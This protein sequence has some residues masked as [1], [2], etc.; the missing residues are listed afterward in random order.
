M[1]DV[2]LAGRNYTTFQAI[3]CLDSGYIE[4]PLD[5]PNLPEG[6]AGLRL[7]VQ[8]ASDPVKDENDRELDVLTQRITRIGTDVANPVVNLWMQNVVIIAGGH[9]HIIN[10]ADL[11]ID[12]DGAGNGPIN[13]EDAIMTYWPGVVDTDYYGYWNIFDGMA[14]Q[15]LDISIVDDSGL[16]VQVYNLDDNSK[17]CYFQID[18]TK[19]VLDT[20]APG[21]AYA[22]AALSEGTESEPKTNYI[23]VTAAAGVCTLVASETLP[24]GAFAWIGKIIVANAATWATEGA[25]AFQRFTEAFQNDSRGALSHVRE[26]LRA[27]GAEYISGCATSFVGTSSVPL[28]TIATGQIYQLHRQTWPVFTAGE[29]YYHGN[30]TTQN[31][32]VAN[33]GAAC[34]FLSD[35]SAIGNKRYNLII[36]GAINIDG[37]ECKVFVNLPNGSY[38]IDSQA[39]ADINN[40]AD[41]TVPDDMRSVAFMIARV[42]IS[43]T[44]STYT[45]LGVYS[46]LGQDPGARSGGTS[47]TSSNEYADSAFRI[48]DN[49]DITKMIAFEAGSVTGT[50]TMTMPN[51]NFTPV[52]G[53][54]NGVAGNLAVWTDANA[55]EDGGAIATLVQFLYCSQQWTDG[56][57]P[58]IQGFVATDRTGAS[59]GSTLTKVYLGNDPRGDPNISVGAVI[60]Y[61][62]SGTNEG[63]AFR[64]YGDGFI[65]QSYRV[66]IDETA[67]P[68]GWEIVTEAAGNSVQ[69]VVSGG[70]T[71]PVAG[72]ATTGGTGVVSTEVVGIAVTTHPKHHHWIDDAYTEEVIY[73]DGGSTDTTYGLTAGVGSLTLGERQHSDDAD[74][75]TT[76]TVTGDSHNHGVGT[77]QHT[78]GLPP[79]VKLILIKRVDNSLH[80]FPALLPDVVGFFDMPNMVLG[81]LGDQDDIVNIPDLVLV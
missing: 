15:K 2:G 81:S 72:A 56:A 5:I 50:K 6:L 19:C 28:L 9:I 4:L 16:K 55:I 38:N 74:M 44:G 1:T 54:G 24:T 75:E 14:Y 36:W 10:G 42:C 76:H 34:R 11:I 62:T 71:T 60:P 18:G 25:Y 59:Y 70:T 67:V 22:E 40:T 31:D 47:S 35:G 30:G 41:Y 51:I 20:T 73:G 49:D 64:S 68:A 66:I 53:G 32:S 21:D 65:N 46:L 63:E 80:S 29:I 78:T 43:V 39:Q 13:V 45:S 52:A 17:N 61:L 33:V 79:S 7:P 77:H 23:Y 26:K 57:E 37:S 12:I 27:M 58:Y 48:F 3:T 69:F 8:G